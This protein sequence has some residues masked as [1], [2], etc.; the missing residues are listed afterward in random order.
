MNISSMVIYLSKQS[1]SDVVLEK[2]SKFSECE[3]IAYE[4]GKIVVVVTSDDIN[5]Q[6][7]AFRKFQS[8]DGV[9]D[10]GMVYSYEEL[11]GDIEL[12]QNAKPVSDSLNDDIDAK[13]IKYS[14]SVYNKL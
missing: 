10:V 4:D 12:A 13:N 11:D 3:V 7:A 14:G 8:F 9:S 6:I 1:F 5:G 2:L